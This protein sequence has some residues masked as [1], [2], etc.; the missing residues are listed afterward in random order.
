MSRYQEIMAMLESISTADIEW[1]VEVE[2]V[3]AFGKQV[4]QW[5]IYTTDELTWLEL[6]EITRHLKGQPRIGS[7]ELYGYSMLYIEWYEA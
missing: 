6:F 7:T 4:H 1:T 2:S 5:T 3:A